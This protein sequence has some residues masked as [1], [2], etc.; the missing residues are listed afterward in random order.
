[1]RIV[2]GRAFDPVRQDGR[3]EVLIDRHLAA[4]FFPNSNPI[5]A[6]I[7]WNAN[8]VSPTYVTQPSNGLTVVGVVDQ[9]RIAD[10]HDDGRPQLYIRAEDWGT[11]ALWFVVRTSRRARVAHPRGARGAPPGRCQGPHG[12]SADDGARSWASCSASNDRARC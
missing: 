7:P 6:T 2:A 8:R 12:R 10:V 11:R 9:A 3:Q 5:G 1:M 4:R